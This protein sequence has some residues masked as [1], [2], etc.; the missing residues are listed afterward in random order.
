MDPEESDNIKF[1]STEARDN[2]KEVLNILHSN[3][4]L[5][6]SNLYLL[7]KIISYPFHLCGIRGDDRLFFYLVEKNL[8]EYSVIIIRR[9]FFDKSGLS[10]K[11][12]KTTHRKLLK[13]EVAKGLDDKIK[14][15]KTPTL[16]KLEARIDNLRNRFLAHIDE[17]SIQASSSEYEISLREMRDITDTIN[18]YFYILA[19]L[20]ETEYEM[21]PYPYLENEPTEYQIGETWIQFDRVVFHHENQSDI[22]KLLDKLALDS[23]LLTIKEEDL[24]EWKYLTKKW[25]QN[26][27]YE[28]NMDFI[29]RIRQKKNLPPID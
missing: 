13:S 28:K 26:G 19:D 15:L 1:V 24:D 3:V 16:T 22:E 2:F 12:F 18:Q 4:A 27:D 5:L 29:N 9:I 14:K 8:I 25:K 10:L 17:D 11:K 6:N 23:R 21:V 7:K 20:I